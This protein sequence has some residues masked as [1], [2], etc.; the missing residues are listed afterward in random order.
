MSQT[1]AEL[2]AQALGA[3]DIEEE[4][5]EV[6]EWGFTVLL[7]GMDAGQRLRLVDAVQAKDKTYMYSDILIELALNPDTGNP[8]F[9]KADREALTKKSG[10]VQ[11]R[12]ALKVMEI[13]GIN[14]DDEGEV[15]IET[16]PTSVGA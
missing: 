2:R 9:D 10:A 1:D 12:L 13:S 16:N 6:P 14:A 7:K 3:D 4:T 15:E 8:F 5:M 11:E